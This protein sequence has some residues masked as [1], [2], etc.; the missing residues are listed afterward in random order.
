MRKKP[1]RMRSSEDVANKEHSSFHG[2]LSDDWEDHLS[3]KHTSVEGEL[4]FRALFF[5][6]R[7][8]PFDLFETKKK[9]NNIQFYVRR[10][11]LPWLIVTN[12]FQS[13]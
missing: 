9:R 5:V 6:P 1:L 4:E 7:R 8:A 13:G 2:S 3:V 11:F 10:V 12:L